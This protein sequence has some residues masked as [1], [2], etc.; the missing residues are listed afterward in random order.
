LG[1]HNPEL[2]RYGSCVRVA[3]GCRY[4]CTRS[5]SETIRS[6]TN[7]SCVAPDTSTVGSGCQFHCDWPDSRREVIAARLA[8]LISADQ[9]FT[10]GAWI[11][12]Q[13]L[14]PRELAYRYAKHCHCQNVSLRAATV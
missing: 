4:Y 7:N 10:I 6:N 5:D 9:S 3:N 8:K 12:W 11:R 2:R 13:E 14:L 1:R